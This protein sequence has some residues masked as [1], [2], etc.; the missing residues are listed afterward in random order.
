M[1]R[2]TPAQNDRGPASSTRR[3]PAAA[4][5]AASTGLAARSARS[6]ASPPATMP[7]CSSGRAGVSDTARSTATGR[8][9]AATASGADSRSAASAP[10]AASRCRDGPLA[11]RSTVTTGPAWTRSP[12]RRSSPASSGAAGHWTLVPCASR[13]SVP[14]TRSPG[15]RSSVRPPPTPATASAPNCSPAR[16]AACRLDLAG[17]YPVTR[18][19]PRSAR[20]IR[21]AA[22]SPRRTA[23]ASTHNGEHTTRGRCSPGGAV[24]ASPGRERSRPRRERIG[25][26]RAR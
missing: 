17:P 10:P 19:V 3:G 13:T 22:R 4:A 14:T 24:T 2:S 25:T 7:G 9:C 18:T 11:S 5:Q 20:P 15:T 6:A 16:A 26:G 8:S 1:A 12:A 21:P 23:S